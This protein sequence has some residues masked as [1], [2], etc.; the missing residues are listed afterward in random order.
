MLASVQLSTS[1]LRQA[2]A[3]SL[4]KL[5]FLKILKSPLPACS[6]LWK[7]ESEP[8][9]FLEQSMHVSR[10]SS[11]ASFESTTF[12]LVT[13]DHTL[14]VGGWEGMGGARG[15][16][17]S[18]SSCD[19]ACFL[20]DSGFDCLL[21]LVLTWVRSGQ[22]LVGSQLWVFGSTCCSCYGGVFATCFSSGWL[23]KATGTTQTKQ[24]REP[25]YDH[26]CRFVLAI[27]RRFI[28]THVLL[29]LFISPISFLY[30]SSVS[31]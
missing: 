5:W 30:L 21:P 19:W 17:A 25:C 10:F 13:F 22:R 6:T 4:I 31:P 15:P 20:A 28:T 2:D 29:A 7:W 14:S 24:R 11:E 16:F 12:L 8:L 27:S 18:S 26:Q 9:D 23:W 3:E 1:V